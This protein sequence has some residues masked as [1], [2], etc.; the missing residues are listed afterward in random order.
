MEYTDLSPSKKVK[1][2]TFLT[3]IMGN[4]PQSLN[5]RLTA[6][7]W[8]QE[9]FA[10]LLLIYPNPTVGLHY[11]VRRLAKCAPFLNQLNPGK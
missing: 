7:K 3:I 8:I 4:L 10:F 5:Q 6:Y 9:S 2:G 1:V 11:T